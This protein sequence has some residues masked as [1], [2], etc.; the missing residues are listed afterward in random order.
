M[1]DILGIDPGATGAIALLGVAGLVFVEDLSA[2][3]AQVAD[4]F[5]AVKAMTL[6]NK[7]IAALE[8]VSAMPGQGVVS[9]FKFGGSYY[10]CRALL[11]YA[12]VPCHLVTPSVWK[13][14][15]GLTGKDK[16]ASLEMARRLFPT[17]DLSKKKHIGRAEA[18]LIAEW[19]RR[20]IL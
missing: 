17:A 11:A 20:N 2:D 12:C 6:P 18:L 14:D 5:R 4:A 1:R 7:T 8:Q 16:D 19:A 10:S 15:L 3:P 9:M 13:R